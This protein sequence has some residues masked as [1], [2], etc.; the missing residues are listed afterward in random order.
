MS[1]F[2]LTYFNVKGR[3]EL[4]R[5]IFAKSGTPFEDER[6]EFAD[7][8]ARKATTPMGQLP[9][10][11][12]KGQDMIQS[13]TIARFVARKCGLAGSTEIEEFL[14]DQFVTTIWMDIANKLIEVFFEKDENLKAKK[15]EERKAPTIEGLQ[16]LTKQVKGDF[17]LGDEMSYA[18]LALFDFEAWLQRI[19]PGVELP[20]KLKAIVN[21]VEADPKVAAYVKARPVT[22]F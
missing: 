16:N 3:A 19:L 22:P 6:I 14:C 2:K 8:P 4:T 12:Y 21:K 18:D 5:L 20:A 10:L 1:D 13:M 15:A 9:I 17:V 11:N 7:W